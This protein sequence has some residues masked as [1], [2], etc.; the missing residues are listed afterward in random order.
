MPASLIITDILIARTV[1]LQLT[2]KSIRFAIPSQGSAFL[3]RIISLL[4]QQLCLLPRLDGQCLR[5]D[6]LSLSAAA[7]VV[8]RVQD[9]TFLQALCEQ[10]SFS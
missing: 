3:T 2:A 7:V 6:T 8:V 4:H 10:E 1:W 5:L 9:E